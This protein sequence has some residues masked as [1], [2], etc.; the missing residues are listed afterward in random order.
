VA[1]QVIAPDSS[2]LVAGFVPEHPFYE[3]ASLGL[4]EVQGGGQLIA[5]T[6]AETYSVL[7]GAAYSH[8]PDNVLPYLTQF[9]DRGPVGLAPTSYPKTLRRLSETGLIGGQVY[10]G[11]IAA[12]AAEAGLRLLS[13]DRRAVR[14]YAALGVDYKILA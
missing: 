9:L 13:L 3:E 12:T 2:V 5:H 7:T 11:L 10:D 8:P 14:T 1:A 6:I 4:S